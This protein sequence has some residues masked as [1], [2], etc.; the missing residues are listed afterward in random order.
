VQKARLDLSKDISKK[1]DPLISS[2]TTMAAHILDVAN[3]VAADRD[4]ILQKHQE[5]VKKLVADV[6]GLWATCSFVLN[7]TGA[8]SMAVATPQAPPATETSTSAA[9]LAY[10]SLFSPVRCP[11]TRRSTVSTRPSTRRT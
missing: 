1:L 11:L 3:S 6:E 2:S 9:K 10:A 4:S 8:P 7:Q 5:P